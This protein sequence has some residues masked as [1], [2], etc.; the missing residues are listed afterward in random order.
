[1]QEPIR[2][3]LAGPVRERLRES[4]RDRVG[5]LEPRE[6]AGLAVIALLIAG[7]TVVWYVRSMPGS[8]SIGT[9]AGP[10]PSAATAPSPSPSP[11]PS[12]SPGVVIVH[13]AGWVAHPGVYE[14]HEGDRVVDAIERAGGARKGA[15]LASINLAAVLVDAQQIVVVRAGAGISSTSGGPGGGAGSGGSV[16]PSP[17]ESL[18]NV[19]TATVEELE[20]LPGIGEVLAQRI[21]D[22]REENGPF[23]AVEDLL[24]VSGIGE[25]RLADISDQV[26]V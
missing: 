1:V 11:G 5:R 9:T 17:G 16:A 14:L 25:S 21:I 18:V 7:G 8:V 4:I 23:D 6:V 10:V 22:H 12:T 15:D 26:T 20:T 3:P 24:E 13:V 19:N 2:D